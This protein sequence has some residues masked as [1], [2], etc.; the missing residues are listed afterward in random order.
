MIYKEEFMEIFDV[1]IIGL[2]AAGATLSMLL[3]KKLKVIAIDKKT[4]Q[5]DSFKKPC[6]G[7]LSPDAQNA[8]A[9]LN[10]NLPK[11]VLVDPQIFY[12]K[13]IDTSMRITK[14]YPRFYLNIDRH[15]FDC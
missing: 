7:L 12:V 13:T 15:K 11:E 1:A 3:D 6:G 8:M 2:G 4:T 10:L 9:K 14:N 5:E